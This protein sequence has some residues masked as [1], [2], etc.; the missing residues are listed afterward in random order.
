MAARSHFYTFANVSHLG[1]PHMGIVDSG[2]CIWHSRR[3]VEDE[4]VSIDVF[5]LH[6]LAT[7]GIATCVDTGWGVR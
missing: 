3:K 1:H 7:D 6:P 2:G 5:L 4:N